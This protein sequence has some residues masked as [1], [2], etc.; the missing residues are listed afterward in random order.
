MNDEK[1][2]KEE[3]TAGLDDLRFFVFFFFF[4]LFLFFFSTLLHSTRWAELELASDEMAEETEE[5]EE[6][7]KEATEWG[8][9][10]PGV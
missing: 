5:E 4:F 1:D 10:H 6:E 9:T 7:K 3:G 2:D 8:R